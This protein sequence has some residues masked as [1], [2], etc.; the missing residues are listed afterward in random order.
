MV[1]IF[2]QNCAVHLQIFFEYVPGWLSTKLGTVDVRKTVFRPNTNS[3]RIVLTILWGGVWSFCKPQGHGGSEGL[4]V[5]ADRSNRRHFFHLWV[6]IV[7]REEGGLGTC[8]VISPVVKVSNQ[9]CSKCLS[10]AFLAF[11]Y[12]LVHFDH[13]AAKWWPSFVFTSPRESSWWQSCFVHT[14][15]RCQYT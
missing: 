10:V 8:D 3:L 6:W 5:F 9:L 14:Q 11:I 1:G 2:E 15:F 12:A 4:F 7:S 13:Q